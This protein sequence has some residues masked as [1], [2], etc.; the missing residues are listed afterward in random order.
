[1]E[2]TRPKRY[3]T[4]LPG[5]SVRTNNLISFETTKPGTNDPPDATQRPSEMPL[6]VLAGSAD[7]TAR[8]EP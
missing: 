5:L 6:R 4:G 3:P 8:G 1:M 7:G 2:F